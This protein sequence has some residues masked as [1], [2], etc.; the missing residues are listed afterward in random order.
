MTSSRDRTLRCGACGAPNGLAEVACRACG[1]SLVDLESNEWADAQA[2]WSVADR[3]AERA[4][5]V[6]SRLLALAVAIGALAA[7]GAASWSGY[8]WLTRNHYLGEEPKYADKVAEEW[9]GQLG[10]EDRFLRRRAALALET[11]AD[12]VN[13]ATARRIVTPLSA[14]LDD[15][16]ETVRDR[17]ASALAKIKAAT[18]VKPGR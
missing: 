5:A 16:D 11:L 4:R 12:R 1:A 2:R 10:S 6:R 17:A 3:R 9:V 18:G 14:A 15:D 8:G 13:E 7:V